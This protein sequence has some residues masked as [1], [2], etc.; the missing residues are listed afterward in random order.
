MGSSPEPVEQLPR[1][2][3]FRALMFALPPVGRRW[4]A[5][6]R[7][8]AAVAV[9]GIALV[10]AGASA[11]ALFVTLG[12]FA[13][14]YGEGRPYRVRAGVVATAG[15]G[16][17]AAAALGASVGTVVPPG[18]VSVLVVSAVSVLATYVVDAL[19]LG[20]PGPLFFALVCAGAQAAVEAGARPWVVLG[21]AAAGVASSV[22][23]SMVGVLADRT[24]PERTAVERA[25]RSVDAFVSADRKT[26]EARHAAGAAVSAAWTALH[27][28][29]H[30]RRGTKP[31]LVATLLAAHRKFADASPGEAVELPPGKLPLPRPSIGYRLRRAVPL[32]SHAALTALRVG[33]GCVVAGEL[34]VAVGFGRPH[35]A[36][37]SALVVLQQG[38]DR[39]RANVRA[40]HR[41]VGTAAGLVLFGLVMMVAPSGIVLILILAVLQF[42]VELVVPRNYAVATVVI[43]PLALLAAG[44]A[45]VPG[46][47]WPAVADRFAQTAIGVAVAV[48]VQYAVVPRAHRKTLGWTG[49]R[50]RAAARTVLAGAPVPRAAARRDLQFELEGATRAGVDS[51]HNEPGWAA[52]RW[53][54]HAAL[55]HDGYD[56]LQA[57]WSAPDAGLREVGR[58]ERAFGR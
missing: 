13:V 11:S 18:P 46:P 27:D 21:C 28:A 8:A 51:V 15:A 14:L 1:V 33:A 49:S 43:T 25:V 16:V 41:F 38:L 9:P 7:A 29:G 47:V 50:V 40:L 45:S 36:V 37:L 44:V 20:P 48:A 19:R 58:W 57:C 17:L 30:P 3:G 39:R 10:L 34:A 12:T 52:E 22:V 6:L 26:A 54:A 55:V 23:V 53:P 42:C 31:D 2:A 24:K 56:L 5:G 4:S 32:R 35:W